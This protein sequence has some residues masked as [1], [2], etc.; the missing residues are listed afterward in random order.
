M[1]LKNLAYEDA[2]KICGKHLRKNDYAENSCDSC[3][4]KLN[5]LGDFCGMSFALINKEF[6]DKEIELKRSENNE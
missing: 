3:P 5:I 4:L 1:K 6:G 2:Q